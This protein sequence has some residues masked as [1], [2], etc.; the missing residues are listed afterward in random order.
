MKIPTVALYDNLR[1]T[2]TGQV[3]A[4]FLL[5]G[6]NYGLRAPDEKERVRLLH[7]ALL[8]SLPGE[9]LML[10]LCSTLDP[11][12]VVDRM[13]HGLDP[14]QCPEWVAECEATLHTI[15]QLR[16]GYRIFWLSVPLANDGTTLSSAWKAARSNIEATLGLPVVKPSPEQLKAAAM[17]ARQVAESI[18]APFYPTPATPAQMVWLHQHMIDRGLYLDGLL[19]TPGPSTVA[20]RRSALPAPLLDEGGRTDDEKKKTGVNPLRR[21]YLKVQSP[22]PGDEDAAS[23]QAMLMVADVPD[24]ELPF[25]GG[26]M[27]GRIDE[28]GLAVDWAMRLTVRSSSEVLRS[29]QRAL[30]TLNEQ[31]NQREGE[32][33]HGVS[34]LDRHA[35]DLSEYAALMESNK[36]EVECQ[37]TFILSV[38]AADPDDVRAQAKALASW[39]SE[40]G[41]K[42][43]QPVGYQQEMW[44]Q[45]HPGVPTSALTREY[46]QLTT[47]EALSAMVPLSTAHVGD[48][49]G[50][51]L[52]ININNGP[53]LD[54]DTPCGSAPLIFHNPD[55]AT[56]RNVSGSTAYIGDLGSGK[57]FALKK[58]AGAIL[59]RG[60][61][62]IVTDRTNMGEWA[63]WAEALTDPRIVD[64]S[65]PA[66]SLDP[67]RIFDPAT[68]SRVAQS[69]LTPLLDIA[70]TSEQGVLLSEV[71]EVDYLTRHNIVGFGSLVDHLADRCTITGAKDLARLIRVFSRKDL[72]RVVFD[73]TLPA[74]N[75]DHP[76]IVVRTHQLTLPKRSE[77][78][79][80][81]LFRQ[82]GLEKLFGRAVFALITAIAKHECFRD[83]DQL[84]AFVVDEAHAVT[85]STEGTNELV[86]FIRDGRKHR[87]VVYLGSHDPDE[88]F[89]SETMRGLIPFRVLMRHKDK[90][91]AQNGLRWLD[92][93]PN[94]PALIE[95]ITK[96]TSP[97]LGDEVPVHRRGECLIR[98]ASGAV[99]RARI[100][101]PALT[102][103]DQAART[104]GR[105]D[106]AA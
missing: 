83:R 74:L 73:D 46:A 37:A 12:Q 58:E 3:W 5:T 93:D 89:P 91:L 98:D 32:L 97:Q 57:S 50:T 92:L 56:D 21:R 22:A 85:S 42:L 13:L 39:F 65:Q 35:G 76:A 19:P 44:W 2:T 90:T 27:L 88:D 66:W 36:L 78:D 28:C 104:G 51:L 25:P 29:N 105:R 69:F 48:S 63:V 41:Y 6:V 33:S 103:R 1:F 79:H 7:Q 52:A 49:A 18:P 43:A 10:G 62:V 59:D 61:R 87:A 9:S 60:G 45:T 84:A 40:A 16:P 70:P 17:K 15:E 38:A 53:M 23:Y 99:G 100:L 82:M 75:L 96:D 77:L 20:K 71:L 94:D 34:A 72:G 68:G 4:D 95:L 106:L 81:H 30:E 14:A 26:E 67:L 31:F 80:E 24:G 47:S 54:E 8:R 11:H 102:S 55:G 101:P 64:V 86:D